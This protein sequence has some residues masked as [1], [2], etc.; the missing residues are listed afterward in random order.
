M[1]DPKH[2]LMTTGEEHPHTLRGR[3]GDISK[4]RGKLK[5]LYNI[6]L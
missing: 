3:I 2:D 1:R 6:A 5:A 4:D